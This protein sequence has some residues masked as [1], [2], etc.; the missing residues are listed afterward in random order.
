LEGLGG[1]TEDDRITNSFFSG[2]E[3][4]TEDIHKYWRDW[5]THG[6]LQYKLLLEGI[7]TV[8]ENY[9]TNS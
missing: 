9:G 3:R 1:V 2:L 8:T 7:E 4:V 6:K 5:N